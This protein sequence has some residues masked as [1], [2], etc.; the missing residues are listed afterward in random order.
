[1]ELGQVESAAE[2]S[3]AAVFVA[4]KIDHWDTVVEAGEVH[5]GHPRSLEAEDSHW[6]A[7]QASQ[8]ARAAYSPWSRRTWC[9]TCRRGW[10]AA[11]LSS[12]GFVRER[13]Q[14][15]WR[16]QHLVVHWRRG[17]QRMEGRVHNDGLAGVDIGPCWWERSRSLL[18]AARHPHPGH[19]GG[20]AHHAGAVARAL[21]TRQER[22]SAPLLM[23]SPGSR[24]RVPEASRYDEALRWSRGRKGSLDG[25]FEQ[26]VGDIPVR[27]RALRRGGEAPIR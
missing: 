22:G 13:L 16:R 23:P 27:F 15:C 4:E 21:S 6:A 3:G 7:P 12:S 20:R 25:R 19:P 24:P 2:D 5:W 9:L 11:R 8:E 17:R 18:P 1:M 10:E 26:K 14:R